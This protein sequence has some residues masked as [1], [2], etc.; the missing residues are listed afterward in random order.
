M[1]RVLVSLLFAGAATALAGCSTPSTPK[2]APGPEAS[3]AGSTSDAGSRF[4]TEGPV[5][6]IAVETA[7]RPG[8]ASGSGPSPRVE[9]PAFPPPTPETSAESVPPPAPPPPSSD[10]PPLGPHPSEPTAR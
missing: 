5:G 2:A 8:P 3:L 1:V 4:M 9:V 6:G 10:A 7:P